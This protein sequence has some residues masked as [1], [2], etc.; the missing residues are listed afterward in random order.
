MVSTDIY[1]H[2]AGNSKEAFDFYK[3]VFRGEF[4]EAKRY[5]D[6]PGGEKM[7]GEDGKKMMHISLR[8]SP[9]TI[10]MASDVLSAENADLK[11]GSNFHICLQAESE[12]EANQ[13]FN[14]LSKDGKIEMPMNKTFWGAYFGQCKDRFGI[15]WMINFQN[16]K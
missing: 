11:Y 6:M 15:M 16:S 14:Q 8:L 10:L 12:K 4:I 3:T 2:F 1:L 13:L 9:S 7:T 5:G